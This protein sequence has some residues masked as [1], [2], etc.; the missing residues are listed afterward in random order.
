MATSP[1]RALLITSNGAGMGHLSRMLAVAVAAG[2]AADPTMLSLSVAFPVVAGHG[3]TGEYCPSAERRFMPDHL[4]HRYLR[5]RIVALAGEVDAQVIAFDGVAPYPGLV[6]ARGDLGEVPMVWI[7]RGMWRPGANDHQLAGSPVFDLII[8]PG[9]LAAAGDRGPTAGRSD[10][11]LVPPI[12]QVDIIDRPDR[13]TAAAELGIDPDRP[14]ALVTLG[15]GRVGEVAGPGAVAV[16]ALLEDRRWQVCVTRPAVAERAVPLVD[17]ERVIE[18]R[19]VYPLAR[20]L[21]AFDAVVSS[22]GYNAVHEFIPVGLPTLL[23][24]NT[25]TR[26]DDQMA[27]AEWLGG[28]G[29]ALTAHPDEAE[30]ITA[31]VRILSIDEVRANLAAACAALPEDRRSGGAAAAAG[32]VMGLRAGAR[33]PVALVARMARSRTAGRQAVK[34]MIGPT[35]TERVRV[36]LG[37]PQTGGIPHRLRVAIVDTPRAAS[38]DGVRDLLFSES[39]PADQIAAGPVVE[40]LLPGSSL[41]YRAERLRIIEDTYRVVST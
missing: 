24:P 10:A 40:H 32:L 28:V 18:L 14:T 6:A 8:E 37:R 11:I 1:V 29:L 9:D 27:R 41:R 17:P 22:A 39:I 5:R 38:A 26:T 33:P 20:Y 4:W 25:A 34:R 35:A 2:C 30:A 13:V 21:G 19:G 12:T 36:L 31:A 7:R 15:T 16:S 23:I 3:L